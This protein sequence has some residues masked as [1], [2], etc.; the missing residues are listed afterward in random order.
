MEWELCAGHC[1]DKHVISP[2]HQEEPS[3]M[4][5]TFIFM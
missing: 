5:T 1:T 2:N 4:G 3:E